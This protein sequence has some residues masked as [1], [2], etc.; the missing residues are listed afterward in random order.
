MKHVLIPFRRHGIKGSSPLALLTIA[1]STIEI[2]G[3]TRNA[4]AIAPAASTD[5]LVTKRTHRQILSRRSIV[6][7]FINRFIALFSLPSQAHLTGS[8]DGSAR[9]GATK[10]PGIVLSYSVCV[11]QHEASDLQSVAF[12]GYCSRK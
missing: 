10:S 12:G 8:G 3:A 7:L 9:D 2:A 11:V 1:L 6:I 4:E 5:S